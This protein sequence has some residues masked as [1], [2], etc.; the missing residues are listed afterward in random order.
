MSYCYYY[1]IADARPRSKN[2]TGTRKNDFLL[3]LPL[4]KCLRIRTQVPAPCSVNDYNAIGE[5]I[6]I[7]P[8]STRLAYPQLILHIFKCNCSIDRKRQ[9][10]SLKYV[11]SYYGQERI[12][13][14]SS[15]KHL[16]IVTRDY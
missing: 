9:D 2:V 5:I 14:F 13:N 12:Y 3:L 11:L 4:P 10:L 8:F 6:I 1:H 7:C 15:N 16:K